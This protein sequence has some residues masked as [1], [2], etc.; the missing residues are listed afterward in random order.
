[1]KSC[2]L[3]FILFVGVFFLGE[4]A[5]A[6]YTDSQV[7]GKY[8][9]VNNGTN[10]LNP[11]PFLVSN[12]EAKNLTDEL[13]IVKLKSSTGLLT[14]LTVGYQKEKAW[15]LEGEFSFRT[16]RR[17]SVT[18]NDQEFSTNSHTDTFTYM[19]N[20]YYHFHLDCRVTPFLGLGSGYTHTTFLLRDEGNKLQITKHRLIS[21]FMAGTRCRITE[22]SDLGLEYCYAIIYK[23][24]DNHGITLKLRYFFN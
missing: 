16:N 17:S 4:E 8:F 10:I 7:H 24:A 13:K 12:T 18:I 19:I 21:Q 20:G 2:K 15:A 9:S 3:I 22:G 14:G 6:D 11:H 5:T 1:M 23:H